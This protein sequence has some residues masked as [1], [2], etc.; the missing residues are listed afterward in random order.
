MLFFVWHISF[1]KVWSYSLCKV[2]AESLQVGHCLQS[3]PRSL[4]IIELLKEALANEAALKEFA[5]GIGTK[6]LRPDWATHLICMLFWHELSSKIY[7]MFYHFLTWKVMMNPGFTRVFTGWM[8]P[9]PAHCYWNNRLSG[10]VHKARPLTS[11]ML[12]HV[13]VWEREIDR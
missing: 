5:Q 11:L 1:R 9:P 13:D 4:G 3:Y 8:P 10:R 12:I 7:I 6:Q 2:P